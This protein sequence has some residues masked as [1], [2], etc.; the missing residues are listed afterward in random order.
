MPFV[1]M[2]RDKPGSLEVRLATRPQHI[3]YLQTYAQ[4]LIQAGPMLD[5]D[6]RPCGS[7]LIV[8]VADRAEAEGFA[9]SDPYFKSGLFESVIIRGYRTVFQDGAVV[10]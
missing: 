8:D 3:A 10:E 1:I 7:I 4:K 5:V 2:C 6:G 9:E